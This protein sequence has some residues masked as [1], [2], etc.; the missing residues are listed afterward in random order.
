[1][2]EHGTPHQGSIDEIDPTT[3]DFRDSGAPQSNRRQMVEGLAAKAEQAQRISQAAVPRE[4]EEPNAVRADLGY[5]DTRPD[6]PL[7][8]LVTHGYAPLLG[9][10]VQGD[11]DI[12]TQRTMIDQMER[13]REAA[14]PREPEPSTGTGRA[15]ARAA[16][17][18]AVA[19]ARADREKRLSA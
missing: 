17:D 6:E 9:R 13:R 8:R 18:E 3:G 5:N 12:V 1:M 19:K 7:P 16:A 4:A 11:H 14:K 2:H 15:R 10:A